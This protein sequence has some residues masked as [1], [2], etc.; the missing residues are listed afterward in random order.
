MANRPVFTITNNK[1]EFFKEVGIDFQYFNGFAA[2]Q[3]AKSIQ[4][5]HENAKA[6]GYKNILEVSTKSD[7]KL[8][9]SLSAFNLMVDFQREHK[10]SLECAFQGSKVFE[11]D[12]QHKDLYYVQSI[13]AKKDPRLKGSKTIIG[14][15]FNGEFWENEP[16]TAFYDYLYIQTLYNNYP[17]IIDEL[18]GFDTFT[19]IEF[20]PKKSINCQARTCAIL[21]SLAKLNL[22]DEAM[23]SKD[24]FID[25]IYRREPIQLEMF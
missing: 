25:M 10:I 3:K 18:M 19:D 11:G 15:N 12:I 24:S 17:D 9:W 5:L 20:N 22:L 14:F 8:G 4:S 1:K 16:K 6:K 23:S 2:S 21:V 13:Q 7:N